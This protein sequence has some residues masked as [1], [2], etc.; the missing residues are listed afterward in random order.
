MEKVELV[1]EY[2]D[3]H[4]LSEL[5]GLVELSP[6]TWYYH[7]K[8]RQ[9][10]P[11]KY[12]HL[13]KPL[14]RI[15]REHPEYGYRRTT[16]E[17]S[18]MIGEAVNH[19]VVQRLHKLWD[20]SIIRGTKRPQPSGIR[21]VI[22]ESGELCNLA[23]RVDDPEP[24]E[25]LYTDFTEL[26]YTRGKSF[27]ILLLDDCSK[28]SVGWAVGEHAD[29]ELALR[30]WDAALD[31]LKDLG[32]SAEGLIVH[33]DRDSV[34]TSYAWTSRLLLDDRVKVSYAL[35][36][37]KDNTSMESF[38]GRFKTENRSLFREAESL[39]ELTKIVNERMKYYN[40]ERRHSALG[41]QA[42]LDWLK[43]NWNKGI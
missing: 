39:E 4:N 13:R 29:T 32:V 23:A 12:S 19:K 18:E 27:L 17:L 25:I 26:H 24:F 22:L 28:Y 35:N 2:R 38:N 40:E 1:K 14:E 5:L 33:H 36:G 8:Y 34:F 37:A 16:T 9:T 11:E 20:L 42:P 10:Y 31:G 30:A 41:N 7:T 21:K 3:R 43:K 15:A 6:S